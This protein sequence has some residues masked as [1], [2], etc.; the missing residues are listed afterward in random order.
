MMQDRFFAPDL[1]SFECF[2]L[3]RIIASFVVGFVSIY[4]RN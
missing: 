4:A 2:L 1:D 3:R